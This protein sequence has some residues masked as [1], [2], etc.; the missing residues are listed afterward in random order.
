MNYLEVVQ[1][2]EP[3]ISRHLFGDTRYSLMW[4]IIRLYVGWEWVDAGW[5]KVNSSAWVGSEA[6]KALTGFVMGA[7]KKTAGEHPD[8]SFFYGWF[9]QHFVLPNA[10]AFSYAVAWGEV[11]VGLGLIFG[12]FTGIAAFFGAFMN[13]NYLFA[14]TVSTNPLLFLLE[15]FLILAWRTAGFLGLDRIVLPLLGTPWFPGKAFK[16]KR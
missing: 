7:L 5:T 2:P 14:G 4:L 9:L 10:A 3:P 1:I 6:G 12:L 11:L 8:V 15:L 16:K 13:M